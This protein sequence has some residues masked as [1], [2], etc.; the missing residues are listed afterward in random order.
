MLLVPG[1]ALVVVDQVAAAVE[2]EA[3]PI[4]LD[5]PRM[6]CRVAVDQVDTTVDQP[7]SEPASTR[8]ALRW[9]VA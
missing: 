7:V 4:D 1:D 5:G 3:V 2:D 6:V 8:P 9:T